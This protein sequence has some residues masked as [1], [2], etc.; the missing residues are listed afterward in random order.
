MK[1]ERALPYIHIGAPRTA[2]TTLQ[3]ALFSKHSQISYIGKPYRKDDPD[4]DTAR[5]GR[6]LYDLFCPIWTCDSVEYEPKAAKAV[7]EEAVALQSY[8][9]I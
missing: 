7:F 3:Q 5:R 8:P 9:A 1:S 6:L 4:A 2:T